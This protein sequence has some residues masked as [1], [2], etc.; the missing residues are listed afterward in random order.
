MNKLVHPLRVRGQSVVAVLLVLTVVSCQP[1]AVM[2]TPTSVVQTVEGTREVSQQVTQIV[3]V[4]VT[5]PPSLTP[6]ISLTP[7][8]TTTATPSLTPDISLTPSPTAT[9]T[10]IPSITPTPH[11][12]RVTI[13][14]HI[15]CWYGPGDTY[16][17]RYGLLATSWMN[18]KGRNPEGTWL[19]LEDGGHD[20]PCWIR[21]IFGKFIGGGDVNSLNIPV[22]DPDAA[23]PP[24]YNLYRPPDGV[25]T[26]RSGNKVT[27]YWNAVWMTEDDYNGY[28]IES[29]LCQAGQL[30][31]KPIG[32]VPPLSQNTGTLGIIIT[33]EPGC[34]LPSSARI[35]TVEKHGY[36]GYIVIPWPPA[37]PSAAITP[38]PS[39]SPTP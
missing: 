14:D 24:A 23:L 18:V 27:L 3:D 21:T 28:L 35:Y 9:L 10:R 5:I 29:W 15:A 33:D 30:V 31:F 37:E 19:L 1:A 7:S 17:E 4:T 25:Q 36:T 39:S 13:L 22:V 32:Y 26:L 20:N 6:D 34:L 2:P 11:Q 8:L 38:S 12:P 16:M